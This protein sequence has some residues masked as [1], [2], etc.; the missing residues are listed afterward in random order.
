[1]FSAFESGVDIKTYG[2]AA[3]HYLQGW[4]FAFF[5]IKQRALEQYQ[6]G[7][8]TA[9]QSDIPTSWHMI[10]VGVFDETIRLETEIGG[11]IPDGTTIKKFI[12]GASS[13]STVSEN[14][15]N[16]MLIGLNWNVAELMRSRKRWPEAYTY[17]AETADIAKKQLEGNPLDA[18]ARIDLIDGLREC[19][20]VRFDEGN[21]PAAV[22]LFNEGLEM[23][24][25]N[26]PAANREAEMHNLEAVARIHFLLG[27]AFQKT[28]DHKASA[29]HFAEKVRCERILS[30][31]YGRDDRRQ[32]V[33]DRTSLTESRAARIRNVK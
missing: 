19:G 24:K 7:L 28:S 33:G 10:D 13:Q 32:S 23:L 4:F 29:E 6:L 14:G 3:G 20:R 27:N 15:K 25:A 2:Q 12:G 21:F 16:S 22:A 1:V 11:S 18:Q 30:S 31:R 9:S 26:A 8:A 17:Y 5:N